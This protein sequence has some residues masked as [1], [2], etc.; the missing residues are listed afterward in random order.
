M[1]FYIFG[2]FDDCKEAI[3]YIQIKKHITVS[4]SIYEPAL[5]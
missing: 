2:L 1:P 3:K 4:F 5:C